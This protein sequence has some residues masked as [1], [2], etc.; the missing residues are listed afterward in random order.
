MALEGGKIVFG[1]AAQADHGE[2]GDGEAQHRRLAIRVIATDH[3]SLFQRPDPAQTGRRRQPDPFR[4]IDVGHPAIFLQQGEDLSIDPV[5]H[6][7]PRL[8]AAIHSRTWP[9]L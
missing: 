6:R 7:I 1:L 9:H 2:D 8:R 3:A 4:Q 5:K